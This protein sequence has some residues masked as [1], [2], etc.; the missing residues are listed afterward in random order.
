[1]LLGWVVACNLL[2]FL[3]QSHSWFLPVAPRETHLHVYNRE[4][5]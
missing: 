3:E 1:M 2:E 5:G 4:A